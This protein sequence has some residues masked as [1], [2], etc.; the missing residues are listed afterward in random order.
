MRRSG[1]DLTLF[2]VAIVSEMIV[3]A[4]PSPFKLSLLAAVFSRNT[5]ILVT[6]VDGFRM[7]PVFGACSNDAQLPRFIEFCVTLQALLSMTAS[8]GWGEP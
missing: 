8:K 5:A 3:R 2:D 1:L 7:P 6:R 4:S